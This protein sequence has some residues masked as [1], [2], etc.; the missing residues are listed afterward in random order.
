[1]ELGLMED[2]SQA[3]PR[4]EWILVPFRLEVSNLV[5]IERKLRAK[6]IISESSN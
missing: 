1:M 6:Q 4:I 5:Q 3:K 2:E